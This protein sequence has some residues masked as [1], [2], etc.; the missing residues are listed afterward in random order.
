VLD[1]FSHQNCSGKLQK[2]ELFSGIP[3]F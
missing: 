3:T 2:P 1:I